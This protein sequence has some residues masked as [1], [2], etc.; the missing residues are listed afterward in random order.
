MRRMNIGRVI[1]VGLA[2]GVLLL[3]SGVPLAA[4]Q[5]V[6]KANVVTATATIQAIDPKTRNV[7]L[8][9]E[10]G[11]EDTYSVSPAVTRFNELKVGDK[12]RMTYYES[13]VLQLL[14]PGDKANPASAEAALTRA[15]GALP[16]GTVATQ[17][18]R[19]VTV[20]SIDMAAP[21]ITVTTEDGRTFT[22]R[23][24]N[25]ANLEGVKPGD[26]IEI[27]Y[28]QAVLASVEPAK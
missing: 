17:E 19:T 8:R 18:K 22:R 6:T 1:V 9:N 13:I 2:A 4:Q 16:G 25:K 28:T 23:V 24:E 3:S 21:S 5:P 26:R 20:K 12:I 15:K 14:K 27:T 7:T 11:E 10:R